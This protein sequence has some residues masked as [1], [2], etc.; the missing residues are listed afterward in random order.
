MKKSWIAFL[1]L[2]GCQ[3][4]SPHQKISMNSD[5]KKRMPA[6]FVYPEAFHNQ[7]II[8]SDERSAIDATNQAMIDF[9]AKAYQNPQDGKRIVHPK[10]H[11]CVRANFATRP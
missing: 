4:N 7:E 8:P 10:T 9:F 11:G 6:E 1:F 3:S 2:L 5:W